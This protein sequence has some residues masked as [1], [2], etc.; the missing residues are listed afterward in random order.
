MEESFQQKASKL[1]AL[2]LSEERAS[3]LLGCGQGAEGFAETF[4][5]AAGASPVA[6]ALPADHQAGSKPGPL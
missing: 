4:V 1:R 3:E 5:P 6:G 2:G